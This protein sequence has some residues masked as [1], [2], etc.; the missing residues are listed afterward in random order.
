MS[1]ECEGLPQLD[2][3]S[4]GS[5]TTKATL[6]NVRETMVESLAVFEHIAKTYPL[7]EST[8]A[9]LLTMIAKIKEILKW[10]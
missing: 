5:K 1:T 6:I 3:Q 9:Q 8:G 10:I 2:R 7:K 4:L